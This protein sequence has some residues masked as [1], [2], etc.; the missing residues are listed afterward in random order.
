MRGAAAAQPRAVEREAGAVGVGPVFGD[1]TAGGLSQRVSSNR[2]LSLASAISGTAG[3]DFGAAGPNSSELDGVCVGWYAL[4]AGLDG[5]LRPWPAAPVVGGL[6]AHERDGERI[7][8][9]EQRRRHDHPETALEFAGS[10]L[11]CG[12]LVG[13]GQYTS[14][15]ITPSSG[16]ISG[17]GQREASTTARPSNS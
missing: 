14:S 8:V 2:R 6:P 7:D 12:I 1:A 4:L 16:R 17:L 5:G 3:D 13:G 11:G 15:S 10:L 9:G